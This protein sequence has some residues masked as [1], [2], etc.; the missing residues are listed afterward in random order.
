VIDVTAKLALGCPSG[1]VHGGVLLLE[2]EELREL[3]DVCELLEL[4]PLLELEDG[5]SRCDELLDGG[6][7]ELL[8]LDRL[9]LDPL[10]ELELP[11]EL[12]DSVLLLGALLELLDSPGGR[13]LLEL[14][15][16]GRYELLD[17]RGGM[18][19]VL[20]RDGGGPP[21]VLPHPQGAGA[22]QPQF[23]GYGGYGGNGG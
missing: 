7:L 2:L 6:T 12:D 18:V 21:C 9:L 15:P 4:V 23:G 14:R 1:S 8:A 10:G 19:L 16:G 5:G 11:I 17:S 22:Q 13:L 3:L 20:L